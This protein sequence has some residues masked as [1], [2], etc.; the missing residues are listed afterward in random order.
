[1]RSFFFLAICFILCAA[2]LSADLTVGQ[3]YGLNFVDVDGHTLSTTDGHVTVVVLT[4][5][6]D[7]DKAR[8][9]GDRVPEYCLGDPTYRL[10]TIVNFQ[11]KR[12]K[13]VRMI[14]SALVRRRLDAEAQRLQPRYAAKKVAHDPRRDVFAVADF[15]GSVVAG[16]G[17]RFEASDF[18]VFVFGRKGE[19]LQQWN[20]VPTAAQLAAVVK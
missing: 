13:P 8:A 19:L 1:M 18:R 14:V 5:R 11:K 20:D 12:S 9:V 2:A 17:A 7:I 3:I 4:T 15:D 10:I 16:L 6:S